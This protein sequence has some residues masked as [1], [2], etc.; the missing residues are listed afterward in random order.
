MHL[1]I[2]DASPQKPLIFKWFATS[3]QAGYISERVDL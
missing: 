2:G 3:L 1:I